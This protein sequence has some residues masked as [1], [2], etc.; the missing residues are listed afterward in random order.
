[1]S[2]NSSY[3]VRPFDS[4]DFDA[5]MALENEVF[6]AAGESVLGPYYVRLCCDFFADTCFL[7]T[8]A[9]KPVGYVLCFIRGDQGYC[10]TLAVHPEY[11]GSRV[12]LMLLRAL[13]SVLHGRVS[14]VW[15]TVKPDNQAARALHALLGAAELGVVRNFYE[16]GDDRIV[17][18][19]DLESLAKRKTR[20]ERLG[21]APVSPS[22]SLAEAS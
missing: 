17:S 7:V 12:V 10:T 22:H 15:F 18:C 5:I 8:S 1:V 19:I 3:R 21:L 6:A 14:S 4:S 11:Q 16:E 13:T 2:P 9:G 20:Y